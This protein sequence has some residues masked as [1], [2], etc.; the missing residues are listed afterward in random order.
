LD[1]RGKQTPPIKLGT[2]GGWGADIANGFCCGGTLGALVTDGSARYLLSNFHVLA[3]DV[4]SGGNARVS[5]LGD[6]VI[7]PGLIDV[8]C[9]VASAQIVGF[10][11]GYGDP[12]GGANVDAAIAKAVAGMVAE[13]GD[14]L[15]IGTLSSAT[16]APFVRQRVKKS[17]RTTGLTSSKVSAVNATVSVAYD[18]EC[19]GGAR[20]TVT[21][22]GQV[23]IENRGSKFLNSGDSGSLMVEEVDVHPRA[24]GLLFAG[25]S[26]VAVANPI[27]EVLSALEVVMVG[28]TTAGA[29]TADEPG[30]TEKAAVA[31]AV[32]AQKKHRLRLEAVP[33]GIG[34]GVGMNARG[35]AVVKVFVESN[36]AAARAALPPSLDGIPV[37]VE[38]VGRIVAF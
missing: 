7:Q 34:H 33:A 3:G 30:P 1:H 36:A 27:D 28:V 19:A 20:G 17:G 35:A 25:S 2:S 11:S 14:I 18:T 37:V 26:T 24:V 8:S 10:L 31:R 13:D 21:F 32:V 29:A 15:G 23:M 12:F 22:T 4:V 6:Q 5:G 38:E 9:N 16:A